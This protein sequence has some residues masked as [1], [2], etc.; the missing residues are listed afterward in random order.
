MNRKAEIKV[1][2]I[3][4]ARM[5]YE[6]LEGIDREWSEYLKEGFKKFIIDMSMV[7]FMDSASIGC[8]MNFYR[9]VRGVGG[10]IH[11]A[12]VRPRIETLLGIVKAKSLFGI[13][14]SVE[15]AQAAF[16]E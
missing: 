11:L 14:R 3:P 4:H 9:R 15:D 2:R 10:Q 7:G 12:G 5:I 16:G 13:Y 1:I 6:Q 8:L